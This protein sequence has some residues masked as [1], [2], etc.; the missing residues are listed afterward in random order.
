METRCGAGGPSS[1]RSR[2]ALSNRGKTGKAQVRSLGEE[3]EYD[4]ETIEE[5]FTHALFVGFAPVDQ[6][7]VVI[8]VVVENGGGGPST[9]APIAKQVL[10]A[11]MLD[12]MTGN[13]RVAQ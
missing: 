6:P 13:V 2:G 8:S 9:A 4:E 3:E 12:P 11:A 7:E 1:R 5:R 10:D